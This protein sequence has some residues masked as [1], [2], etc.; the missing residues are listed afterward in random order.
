VLNGALQA[1]HVVHLGLG[2]SDEHGGVQLPVVVL[3]LLGKAQR[4]LAVVACRLQVAQLQVAATDLVIQPRVL[5]VALG[6]RELALPGRNRLLVLAVASVNA[7]DVL[8]RSRDALLIVTAQGNCFKKGELKNF[9]T[10]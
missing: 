4:L 6:H 1:R 2:L 9:D 7:A 5:H 3:H 8:V 10:K